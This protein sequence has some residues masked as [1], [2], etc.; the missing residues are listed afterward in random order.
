MDVI[1]IF[2]L[3]ITKTRTVTSHDL[4]GLLLPSAATHESVVSLECCVAHSKVRPS[5]SLLCGLCSML[6]SSCSMSCLTHS[7]NMR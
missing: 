3:L 7:V 6:C 2:V 1:V 4:R 5:F